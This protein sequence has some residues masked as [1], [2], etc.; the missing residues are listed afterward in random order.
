[1]T[2]LAPARPAVRRTLLRLHR[3][4]LL[5]WTAFVLLA[6]GALFWVHHTAA[7]GTGTARAPAT[8]AP[9]PPSPTRTTS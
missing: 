1:M 4:A 2:A 7:P 9:T 6:A 3:P 5:V 8:G